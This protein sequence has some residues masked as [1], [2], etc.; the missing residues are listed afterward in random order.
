MFNH[1]S[2]NLNL[3][4]QRNEAGKTE[5]GEC[6]FTEIKKRE[7]TLIELPKLPELPEFTKITRIY[8]NYQ[9]LPEN[10]PN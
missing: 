7:I 4:L 9:N 1:V 6:E 2:R 3:L 5:N 10:Y 8:Q